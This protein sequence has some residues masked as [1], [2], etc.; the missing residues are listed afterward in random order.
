LS[1]ES[2][3]AKPRV[4]LTLTVCLEDAGELDVQHDHILAF[5]YAESR[6]V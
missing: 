1:K 3:L 2:A 5:V 4:D 6:H